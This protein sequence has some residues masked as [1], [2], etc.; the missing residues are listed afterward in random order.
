MIDKFLN[1]EPEKKD[2]I[3]NAA[4][5]EFAREGYKNASTNEIVKNANI[6]KGLI[7]HYFENKKGLFLFLIDYT[8]NIF[9]D[10]LYG[11]INYEETD[12]LKRWGQVVLLKIEL[13]QK[14]PSLYAFLLKAFFDDSSEIRQ[15]LERID[16]SIVE[17]AYRRLLINLDTGALKN[18]MDS[19]RVIKM[20]IWVTQGFSNDELEKMKNNPE[21]RA[22]FDIAAVKPE[23]DAYMEL[24][25]KAFYK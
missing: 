14:Y 15:E 20:I 16:K 10:E 18:G 5:E 13:I 22:N 23:F 4:L 21:Y 19:E 6:S 24:L 11:R 17:D 12:I 9:A 3:I 7:F 25:K 1:L 8:I 2:R